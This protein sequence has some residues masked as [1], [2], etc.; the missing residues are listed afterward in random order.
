M[1][2]LTRIKQILFH[3]ITHW[4]ISFFRDVMQCFPQITNL[5]F[6]IN[7]KASISSREF[8]KIAAAI[9]CMDPNLLDI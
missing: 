2:M 6:C 5:P 1:Y 7:L 3:E 4:K 8:R 9:K